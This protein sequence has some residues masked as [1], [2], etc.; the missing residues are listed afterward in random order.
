LLLGRL[1]KRT[2]YEPVFVIYPYPTRDLDARRCEAEGVRHIE[3]PVVSRDR[4]HVP[5]VTPLAE[6]ERS[7][8][9]IRALLRRFDL[10]MVVLGGDMVGYDSAIWIREAHA[11]DVRVVV[12]PSTMSDGLEH[13]EVYYHDPTHQLTGINRIVARLY[14]KWV[15][16]HR[17]KKLLRVPGGRVLAMEWLGLAPPL[18]WIFN[19]GFADAIAIE[20]DAMLAYYER[21][22][23]TGKQLTVTGTLSDDVLAEAK[24]EA[25]PRREELYRSLGLPPDRP[26]LL[27]PLPPDFLYIAGNRP[28]CEFRQYAELVDYWIASLRA[29]TTHNIVISLHPSVR[30]EEMKHIESDRVRI[31]RQSTSSLV[32]LA[33]LYVASVSST[34]RWAIACGIPVVNYDVYRYRYRDYVDVDGVL[35]TE[36]KA[37]FRDWLARD[38]VFF[39]E[40]RARQAKNAPRWGTLDGKSHERILALIS[41]H[42]R[43]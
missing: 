28:E 7:R 8:R 16:E 42:V 6:L 31:G 13:A 3:A 11:R 40:I 23:L 9:K 22:G 33:D 19:S 36:D 10:A 21:C 27:S 20:S 32:P 1:L 4:V 24:R 12:L 17:G 37:Q 26:M 34:I 5:V 15:R 18:P 35:N 30:Y 43:K 2:E 14:P 39:D 38:A 25:V 41:E 29:V